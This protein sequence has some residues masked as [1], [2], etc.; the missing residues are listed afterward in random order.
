MDEI[1]DFV[2]E[3][4]TDMLKN[5]RALLKLSEVIINRVAGLNNELDD[6]IVLMKMM[7][8]SIEQIQKTI[9]TQNETIK[10]IKDHYIQ[11]KVM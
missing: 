1:K 2:V 7:A 6:Y 4:S 9:N 10:L 5:D 8:N 11:K 3:L